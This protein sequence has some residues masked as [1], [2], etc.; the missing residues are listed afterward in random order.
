MHMTL[1]EQ[2]QALRAEMLQRR[3]SLPQHERQAKSAL[4]CDRLLKLP[5]MVR[6]G[7]IFCYVSYKSEVETHDLIRRML[8]NDRTVS[9]PWIDHN[10]RQLIP[11][12]IRSIERDLTPGR[13][14]I[15]EPRPERLSPAPVD[16]IDM[17]V[18][19]GL[20]FSETGWR[21]G[22]GGGYYDRFLRASGKAACG[23]AFEL[24]IVPDLPRDPGRD[25]LLDCVVT[26]ERVVVCRPSAGP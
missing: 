22:Y 16:E 20:A 13:Y 26:E 14:G 7:H 1:H 3:D 6:A 19:P 15:L 9:V 18:L 24:Q 12:R 11:A 21:I 23:L 10:Q 2:K 5:A 25:A 8:A 17:V 4:I